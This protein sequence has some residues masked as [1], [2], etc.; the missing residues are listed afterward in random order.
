MCCREGV[1]KAPKAPKT[2]FVSATS[3]INPSKFSGHAGR[4]GHLANAKK[5][6]VEQGTE[7]EAVD[8]ASGQPLG[9]YEK[10]PPNAFKNLKRLHENVTKGR[11]AP[12]VIKKRPSSAYIKG[13]PHISF[14][15]KDASAETS[16]DKLTTDYEADWMGDLPSPSALLGKPVEKIGSLPE[17]TSSDCGDS[18]ADGHPSACAPLHQT[19]A[20]ARDYPDEDSLEWF[21]LSQ[22]NDDE[23]ETEA[24]MIGL[25]DSID[26][27][28]G[29][30]VNAAT[31]LTNSQT[32]V[33][34]PAPDEFT[35]KMYHHP[36][37]R[38]GGSGTSRLFF[39]TESPEKVTE[40]GQK[41]KAAVSGD[42][43]DLSQSA[44]VPKRPT[45]SNEHDQAPRP[46]SSAEKH[47]LPPTT[48]VKPGQPA[49]VYE[50]DA[51]FIADWQ[52][53]IDFV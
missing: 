17:H 36:T 6:A 9:R 41:R 35:P 12:V 16:S 7:I 13:G 10:T 38:A 44:P 47:M 39:S 31:D 30:Q 51:A 22:F 24:A 27:Q 20:A 29:L 33:L 42:A 40:L 26:M 50:F 37:V 23:S 45:V 52:D 49:W 48:I 14:L 3:L 19:D 28:K 18:W 32:D 4:T 53:I 1:D 34:S 43:E 2:S 5:S 15:N 25:S 8:L 21:D 11:T 46:S